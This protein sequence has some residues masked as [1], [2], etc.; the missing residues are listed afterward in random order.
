MRG[1]SAKELLGYRFTARAYVVYADEAGNRVYVY[2]D[3]ARENTAVE[4]GQCSKSVFGIAKAIALAEM[5][6]GAPE[7]AEV[8][9]IAEKTEA[10]TELEKVILLEYINDNIG[11][12]PQ[13]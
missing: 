6:L 9:E 7:N 8:R 2:S 12:L 13:D 11:V 10:A 1:T 4:N 3:N 5:E